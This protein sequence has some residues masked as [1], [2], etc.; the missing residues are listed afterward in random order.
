VPQVNADG[1]DLGG[2]TLPE[3]SVPLA[4]YTS[5][6]L[7]HP[8]IGS[9]DRMVSFIGSY[10]PLTKTRAARLALGDPRLSLEERYRSRADYLSRFRRAAQDLV[11]QRWILPEDLPALMQRAAQEWDYAMR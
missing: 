4:T 11:N 5:W 8:S 6:T 7:R 9:P 3:L 1:N 10:L 2:V